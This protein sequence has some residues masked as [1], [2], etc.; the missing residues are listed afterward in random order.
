M[1]SSLHQCLKYIVNGTSI[2]IKVEETL[3][4]V[5]NMAIPYIEAKETK[6]ENLHAFEIVNIE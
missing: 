5:Q 3:V 4:M 2:I 6:D 1:T